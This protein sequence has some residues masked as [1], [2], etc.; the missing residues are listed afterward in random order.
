[1]MMITTRCASV[2]PIVLICS[3][4]SVSSKCNDL[5]T[6]NKKV[7]THTHT[8]DLISLVYVSA[9]GVFVLHHRLDCLAQSVAQRRASI[10]LAWLTSSLRNSLRNA[11][12]HT[13]LNGRLI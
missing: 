4:V 3:K 13:E 8:D 1:M 6:C 10:C 12:M 5:A 7:H 11:H 9:F 2:W